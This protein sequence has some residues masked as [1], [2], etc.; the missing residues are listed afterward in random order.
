[1]LNPFPE[2]LTYSQIAPFVLRI[3][4]G[5]I[6]IDLAYLKVYKERL[7][8][9]RSFEALGLRPADT[10]VYIYAAIEFVA[11]LLLIL[12]LYTQ[13]AALA[14]AVVTGIEIFLEWKDG[15]FFKRDLVFY[16]LLFI[17]AIS[18]LLTGAGAFAF[19]IPL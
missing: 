12:G 11:G 9:R 4:L 19:D 8:W 16:I 2:L 10:L 6:F 13:I 3:V 18:L 1:M 5:L 14:I 7:D 15:N 17:I